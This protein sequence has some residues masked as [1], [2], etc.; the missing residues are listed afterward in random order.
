MCNKKDEPRET[1]RWLGA[2]IDSSLTIPDQ[3]TRRVAER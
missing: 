2:V 1:T 3:R